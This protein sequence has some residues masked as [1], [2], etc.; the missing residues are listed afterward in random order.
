MHSALLIDLLTQSVRD[1]YVQF[2]SILT[3]FLV[4]TLEIWILDSDLM[5]SITCFALFL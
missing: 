5:Q 2:E 4:Q 1:S 3:K